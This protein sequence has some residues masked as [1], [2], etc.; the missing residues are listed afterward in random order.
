[1]IFLIEA[2]I[3]GEPDEDVILIDLTFPFAAILI[4]T[5]TS[6]F[7][8]M[9]FTS[10]KS[11][12]KFNLT[13]FPISCKN[14]VYSAFLTKLSGAS[15]EIFAIVGL[16][17]GFV[18]LLSSFFYIWYVDLFFAFF[19]FLFISFYSPHAFVHSRATNNIFSLSSETGSFV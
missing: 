1:M 5:F 11:F 9:S 4:S 2:S 3:A 18:C 16:Y 12:C 10:N 8:G 17:V 6:L 7:T 15:Q 13:F 14:F 19:L